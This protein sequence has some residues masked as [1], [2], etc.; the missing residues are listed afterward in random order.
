MFG[1]QEPLRLASVQRMETHTFSINE[2][3]LLAQVGHTSPAILEL[4]RKLDAEDARIRRLL[5]DAPEGFH[6]EA[7]WERCEDFAS[8]SVR[9]RIVH[10]LKENY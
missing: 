8:F 10:R 7:D 6:W 2:E 9:F 5:P 3:D 1:E 4:I